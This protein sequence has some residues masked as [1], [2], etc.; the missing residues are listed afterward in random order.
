MINPDSANI[1]AIIE[2]K[3][4]ENCISQENIL[5]LEVY[6]ARVIPHLA[7]ILTPLRDLLQK[8]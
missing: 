5:A 4:T 2:M 3:P 7:D 1:A 8:D 6:L